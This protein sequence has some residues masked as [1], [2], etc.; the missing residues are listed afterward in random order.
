M[1]SVSR[2]T[3]PGSCGSILPS[4]PASQTDLKGSR[5][6]QAMPSRT[7]T[8]A[9]PTTSRPAS[10]GVPRAQ[11]NRRW[12][13]PVMPGP[14]ARCCSTSARTYRAQQPI[15]Q[16]WRWAGHRRFH[17]SSI[18]AAPGLPMR[19][20]TPAR[21][22]PTRSAP[23]IC[24]PTQ[25]TQPWTPSQHP[26]PTTTRTRTPP[27]PAKCNP[28]LTAIRSF[29]PDLRSPPRQ[30]TAASPSRLSGSLP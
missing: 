24:R 2:L 6:P 25:P 20:H 18:R 8:V 21:R 30:T 19:K 12:S 4:A 27:W 14:T 3:E 29:R 9:L 17:P 23:R 1:R 16:A 28:K 11:P 7:T 10:A 15:W 13:R 5:L 22:P 26:S